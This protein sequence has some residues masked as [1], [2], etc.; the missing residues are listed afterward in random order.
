MFGS[1]TE[2]SLVKYGELV[3]RKKG[4]TQGCE[5]MDNA[6]VGHVDDS[7]I[8]ND[9]SKEHLKK[10]PKGRDHDYTECLRVRP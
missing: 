7:F 10:K 3:R 8:D 2:I 6:G 4:A 5:W 1:F 9:G